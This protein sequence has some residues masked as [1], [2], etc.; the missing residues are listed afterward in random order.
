MTIL[1]QRHPLET[2]LQAA[3]TP[4]ILTLNQDF[5]SAGNRGPGPKILRNLLSLPQ[6][7]QNPGEAD[8]QVPSP[9]SLIYSKLAVEVRVDSNLPWATS[10]PHQDDSPAL[11]SP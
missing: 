6:Q 9:N 7:L 3:G 1:R 8:L 2:R 5:L 4:V 10:T 11:Q